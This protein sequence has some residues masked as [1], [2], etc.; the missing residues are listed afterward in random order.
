MTT[1]VSPSPRTPHKLSL[2]EPR[3]PTTDGYE[4]GWC[5]PAGVF[6]PLLIPILTSENTPSAKKMMAI[7]PRMTGIVTARS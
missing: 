4:I 6:F 2:P 5:L 7:V 1:C 3:L